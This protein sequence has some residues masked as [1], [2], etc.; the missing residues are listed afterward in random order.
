[1]NSNIK[2]TPIS[3]CRKAFRLVEIVHTIHFILTVLDGVIE[4]LDTVLV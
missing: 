2:T 1:M 3:L 4:W